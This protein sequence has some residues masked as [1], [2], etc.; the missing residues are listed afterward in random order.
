ML[1]SQFCI[2]VIYLV[3]PSARFLFFFVN[4]QVVFLSCS[5][6]LFL[7]E[8]SFCSVFLGCGILA[9]ALQFVHGIYPARSKSPDSASPSWQNK[10]S[11]VSQHARRDLNVAITKVHYSTECGRKHARDVQCCREALHNCGQ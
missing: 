7:R 3:K 5:R 9:P 8:R 2:V 10:T 6:V 11:I 4:I 1:V